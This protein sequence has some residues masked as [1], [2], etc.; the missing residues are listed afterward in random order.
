MTKT[1]Q[2]RLW[3]ADFEQGEEDARAGLPSNAGCYGE[4]YA[5]GYERAIDEITDQWKDED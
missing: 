4:A 5:V 1:E 2:T 3:N